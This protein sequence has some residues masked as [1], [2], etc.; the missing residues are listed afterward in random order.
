MLTLSRDSL[1]V[2]AIPSNLLVCYSISALWLR[3]DG[4]LLPNEGQ[5]LILDHIRKKSTEP[6][7]SPLDKLPA[8]EVATESE[9]SVIEVLVLGRK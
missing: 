2:I 7:W 3:E 5:G 6:L 4:I 9:V 1:G 8:R